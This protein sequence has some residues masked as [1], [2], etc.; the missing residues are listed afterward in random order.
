MQFFVRQKVHLR[1][2][3]IVPGADD[4]VHP[5]APPSAKCRK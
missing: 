2:A 5:E 1:V 4:E 3:E